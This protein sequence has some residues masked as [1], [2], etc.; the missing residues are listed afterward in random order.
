MMEQVN[1]ALE[2]LYPTRRW[3]ERA[4]EQALTAG[5]AEEEGRL[6]ARALS[7]KLKAFALYKPGAEE[8]FSDYIYVLCFGRQPSALEVREG[9]ASLDDFVAQAPEGQE[10]G[11]TEVY[12]RVALS[13]LAPFAA[14]QEVRVS[15]SAWG[16]GAHEPSAQAF[17]EE[18]VRAG[19]FDPILLPRYQKLVAVLAEQNI[20]NI[21]FGEI[22]AAP[23]DFDGAAHEEMFGT[24]A[25]T[26]NYLFFAGPTAGIAAELVTARGAHAGRNTIETFAESAPSPTLA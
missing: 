5:V 10:S 13:S 2:R 26:A 23:A 11:I 1:A 8:D 22:N 20:R 7:E 24:E 25:T 3:H 6:L 21:D 4:N 18:H 12:L 19:V 9:L 15:L 16:Q 17:V 14:V